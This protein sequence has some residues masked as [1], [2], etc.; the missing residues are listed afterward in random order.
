[1]KAI[2]LAAGMGTRFRPLTEARP[3][4]MLPVGHQPLLAHIVDAVQTAGIE[5]LVFVV[6]HKRE[7]IQNYFEGGADWGVSIEYVTQERPRGTGDALLQAEPVV[8]DGC[9]VINGDRLVEPAL[10]ENLL[11]AHG[12]TDDAQMTVTTARDPTEYGTVELD[13][14]TLTS[15]EEK[16]A[17]HEISSNLVNAGVYVFNPD[18]FAAIRQTDTRGELELTDTI[19]EYLASHPIRAVRYD[20][21]WIELSRLWDLLGASS[22][23]LA[24]HSTP[25]AESAA[26]SDD[27]TVGPRVAVG[28]DARIQP[29]ARL[30]RDVV[31]GE[32]VTVGANT[33]LTNT[34]V[35]EDAVIGAGSVL[36][37]CIVGAGARV[38]PL[39]AAEGGHADVRVNETIY[40][41][42]TFGGVIG[43][44]TT[45]GG[46]V[47]IAPGTIVGNNVVAEANTALSGTHADDSHIT[48][49]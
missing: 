9:L 2:I 1:M 13:D 33:V 39:V 30:T 6:G 21:L 8:G 42:V 34:I 41:D 10:L 5:E 25:T 48:T 22:T 38:G 47:T 43:D 35:L 28:E 18:I 15:I 16:P 45:V 40:S 12:E 27:A 7:R 14:G 29:G 31:I 49:G 32:N 17:P 24:K 46:H 37:D 23:V 11:D 19:S 26:I 20:G 3:K 36:T 44:N 4:S